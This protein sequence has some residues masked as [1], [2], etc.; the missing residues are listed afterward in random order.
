MAADQLSADTSRNSRMVGLVNL[1]PF[2]KLLYGS[3]CIS[4]FLKEA[5]SGDNL[6]NG[7]LLGAGLSSGMVSVWKI[8]L[9]KG[10]IEE[11]SDSLNSFSCPSQCAVLSCSPDSR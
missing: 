2:M 8:I 5:A 7:V 3:M 4:L 1:S 11:V 6:E 9:A 10:R